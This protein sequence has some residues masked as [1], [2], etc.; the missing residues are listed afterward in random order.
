MVFSLLAVSAGIQYTKGVVVWN[1]HASNTTASR[2]RHIDKA[3]DSDRDRDSD[4]DITVKA[5]RWLPSQASM[6]A[7]SLD[8]CLLCLLDVRND[9]DNKNDNK[10]DSKTNNI[11]ESLPYH[12]VGLAI[13]SNPTQ[14]SPSAGT[15][16]SATSSFTASDICNLPPIEHEV[17]RDFVVV[18]TLERGEHNLHLQLYFCLQRNAL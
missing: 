8:G 6:R 15:A 17:I 4:R 10:N 11:L 7:S 13:D 2:D 1:T 12:V 16:V 3:I 14:Q 18:P 9:N 5:L